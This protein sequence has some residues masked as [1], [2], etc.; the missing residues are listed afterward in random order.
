[1]LWIKSQTLVLAQ[2]KKKQKKNSETGIS[3]GRLSWF[4]PAPVHD[5]LRDTTVHTSDTLVMWYYNSSFAVYSQMNSFCDA[6]KRVRFH[7]KRVCWFLY[8]CLNVL[9][10]KAV[11]EDAHR[12]GVF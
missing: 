12:K 5:G 8:K 7:T 1:M 11:R 6:N 10:H 9:F 3:I 4:F 2:T